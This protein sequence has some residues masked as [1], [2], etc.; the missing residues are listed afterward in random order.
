M[1]RLSGWFTRT[2][3]LVIVTGVVL[4][5]AVVIDPRLATGLGGQPDLRLLIEMTGLLLAVTGAI[6][7]ALTDR[8]DLGP[9]RDLFLA[10]LLVL[11]VTN[12]VFSVGP[13]V[14]DARPAIDR[15]LAF[16]P[17][18]ASR[19]V[20]GGLMLLACWGRPRL[21]AGTSIAAGLGLLALVE[22]GLVLLGARL[23]PP[24]AIDPASGTV[25]VL[26]PASLLVLMVIPAMMFATGSWLAARLY[27]RVQAPLYA[28]LSLAMT[29]Q[30]FAQVHGVISPAFLGPVVT[31]MDAFRT[32]S[33]VMFAGGAVM[34]LRHLYRTRSRTAAQQGVDLREQRQALAALQ[35]LTD[36]EQDFQAVVSH[37]LATPIAAVR[38]FVHV[39]DSPA[40]QPELRHVALQGIRSEIGRLTELVDRI[41]ELRD[42][43]GATL[44][45][46]LRPVPIRVLLEEIRSFS[47]GLPGRVVVNLRAQE[48]RV[49]ADPV[50]LGQLLRN[51]I[52]NAV[53]HG[54]EEGPVDLLGEAEPGGFYR[55]RVIDRGPGIPV[56]QR[57]RVFEPYARGTAGGDRPGMGLGLYIARRLAEAHGG[58]LTILDGPE[59]VGTEMRLTLRRAS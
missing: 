28:W 27:E 2:H 55:I 57:A 43:G 5:A 35:R 45:V 6:V 17:W 4:T 23:A 58:R 31:T 16:Y 20:A 3:A 32:G 10:A 25:E 8:A 36:R 24:V 54:P 42:L 30:V 15:G 39:L 26:L 22:A 19:F 59:G 53:A 52:S 40:A 38:A 44:A 1:P 13:A 34:Q 33:W 18:A 29:M 14:F 46:E 9:S 41:E 56:D 48:D 50:R 49:L 51:L 12:A 21:G 11:A 47:T 7:L 37:E